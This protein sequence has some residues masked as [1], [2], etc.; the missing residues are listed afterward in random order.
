[1]ESSVTSSHHVAH[2]PARRAAEPSV[3]VKSRRAR[4]LFARH[5][6]VFAGSI[7]R[8]EG[9]PRDGDVVSVYT[10][11][12]EFIARGLFNAQSQIQVRLYSWDPAQ[13]L[14]DEFWRT[15][16]ADAL[17]LRRDIL[18]L[19][20]PAGACRLVYS[21]GDGLSG[22]IVDRYAGWLAVQF[23]SLALAMRQKVLVE[24][25]VDLCRPRGVYL[26]TERGIGLVEGLRLSDGPIW[27]ES[28][29]GTIVI[30]ENGLEF[31]VDLCSGQK[32]GFYLDQREN[33]RAVAAYSNGR[34]VLDVFCY[35]GGFAMAAARAG[36]VSVLGIDASQ[37]AIALAQRN[38]QRN[39]LQN[40]RF[41][42]GQAFE[43]MEQ[44]VEA[45]S[46]ANRFDMVILDPPKFARQSR[47]VDQALRGYMRANSLALRLLNVDGILVTCSCSGHVSSDEFGAMLGAVAEQGGRTIQMLAQL[48]QSADHPVS[49]SCPESRYLK[50]TIARVV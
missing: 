38:A 25:L 3:L 2:D 27:G 6:W 41:E 11:S 44:L 22:L 39:R 1:M 15:R 20:D 26:R 43:T 50:C 28:P 48:G 24:S 42:V 49:A 29:A 5:P 45:E 9:N 47:A 34:R 16:L 10:H 31:E 14:D 37:A 4:P 8:V 12:G 40:T 18:K 13:P 17:R 19:D 30:A 35:S 46:A 32:T 21:E 23:T 36:A 33:R 7:D